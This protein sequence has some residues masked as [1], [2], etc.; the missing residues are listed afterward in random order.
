[1]GDAAD[2]S[3]SA[4]NLG[5]G[6][7]VKCFTVCGGSCVICL[8]GWMHSNEYMDFLDS[9]QQGGYGQNKKSGLGQLGICQIAAHHVYQEINGM[10]CV[11]G[12]GKELLRVEAEGNA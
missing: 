12:N 1:M 10:V 3:S 5:K 9:D 2:G 11:E 7:A 4:P 6:K 8:D